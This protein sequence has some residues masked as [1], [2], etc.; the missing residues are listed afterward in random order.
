[1]LKPKSF[2]PVTW[3]RAVAVMGSVGFHSM[4]LAFA[5]R[6]PGW[7]MAGPDAG[8]DQGAAFFVEAAPE[9]PG[10]PAA[11]EEPDA[12]VSPPDAAEALTPPP[13]LQ[14]APA[15]EMIL[16]LETTAQRAGAGAPPKPA[17]HAG[18]HG[19]A[20]GRAGKLAGSGSG[21]GGGGGGT[22]MA[23]SYLRNP[24]PA[25]PREARM[26][27]REGTVVLDVTVSA[28]GRPED[29]EVARSSGDPEMDRAA[30]AAV[31]RWSF[32]PA[33]AGG[34]AV[35]ARVEVPVRFRLK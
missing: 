34:Q 27:H 13:L 35:A 3:A 22:Y 10:P 1:M 2:L 17:V 25:Y 8:G 12:A 26:A 19:A 11:V 21:H 18:H 28:D 31:A 9:P 14:P 7:D 4:V 29:V 15:A 16:P 5:L 32:H 20:S 33:M 6:H 30:V 24:A 23:P